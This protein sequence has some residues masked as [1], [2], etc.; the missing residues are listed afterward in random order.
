MSSFIYLILR[1]F[2]DSKKENMRFEVHT[3][4]I[5]EL[6]ILYLQVSSKFILLNKKR[7]NRN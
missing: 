3:V 7:T 2:S 1:A 6:G 5:L 4:D